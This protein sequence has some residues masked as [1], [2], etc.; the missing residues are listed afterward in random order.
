M[1][2]PK[3]VAIAALVAFM[4]F[5]PNASAHIIKPTGCYKQAS[6]RDDGGVFLRKCLAYVS[7]HNLAVQCKAPRP[8]V[9]ATVRVKGVRADRQQRIIITRI[10]NLGRRLNVPPSHQVAVI[11]AATQES[12]VQNLNGGHGTS[13]GILQLTN[14]HGTVQWRRVVENSAGWHFRGLDQLDPRGQAPLATGPSG[15]GLIQRVQK[16]GHPYAYNQWI[17]EARRTYKAFLGACRR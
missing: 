16:S 6:A 11:A 10:L 8:L 4:A 2:S 9:P 3:R 14:I 1:F 5:A 17:P 13:V 7:G 12:T 15:P